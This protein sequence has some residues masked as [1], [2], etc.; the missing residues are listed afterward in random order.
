MLIAI[1]AAAMP[2]A[3]VSVNVV[4]AATARFVFATPA[5]VVAGTPFPFS[6]TAEDRFGNVETGYTGT[7]HFNAEAQDTQAAV[8]ADYT[9]TAADAGTHSFTA[10]LT[11]TQTDTIVP[12]LTATDTA[13]RVTSSQFMNVTPQAATQLSVTSV[14]SSLVAGQLTG[15]TVSAFDVFGN[16]ASGFA[17]TIHFSSSD[18]RASLPAD[19]T[20]TANNRGFAGFGVTFDTAGTQSLGVTDT[21]N[22]ALGESQSGIVVVPAAPTAWVFTGLPASSTAGTNQSFTLTAF[23]PFGNVAT[24]YFGRVHFTSSDSQAVLP[25][26]YT[27]T[28]ADAGSHTFTAV[29]KTAGNQTITVTDTVNIVFTGSQSMAVTPAS[30]ASLSVAGFP[31]T[32]AGVAQT[33]TVTLRDAFGNIA[34]GYAG[35]VAITSSD[36]L[37]SLPASYTFTAADAGVHTFTATL[38]KAGTQSITVKDTAVPTLSSTQAGI[39]VAAAAVS[40]FAISGPTSVTQGVG[41]SITVS[42][43]D[44]FG[45]VNTGY[46]GT[47]H[48]SSTDPKAGTQNFTFS[49]ND[50]GVHVFSYTFNA[51]GAQAITIVDTINKLPSSGLSSRTW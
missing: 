20:F 16:L 9:F 8:P 10:T 33:F 35:T 19:F 46:R 43:L 32:T 26:D 37:A 44:A 7:V 24:N 30:A 23:D 3:S 15:V 28:T 31:A 11:R 48:L 42:A 1:F 45:N 38:K 14:P 50:N 27:F 34:S 41:F 22:P 47:V 21:S 2:S 13:T 5:S 12:E 49:N 51:L 25:A 29:L 40:Q 4:P 36:P 6:L 18:P 39:T 17:G